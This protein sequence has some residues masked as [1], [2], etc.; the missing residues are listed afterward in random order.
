MREKNVR[1]FWQTVLPILFLSLLFS[2]CKVV[3]SISEYNLPKEGLHAE[4]RDKPKEA[5]EPSSFTKTQISLLASTLKGLNPYI[6]QDY[7]IEMILKL[8]YQGLMTLTASGEIMEQLANEVILSEDTLSCQIDLGE[9]YFHNGSKVGYKDILYSW[10]K[11]KEGRYAEEVAAIKKISPLKND[12]IQVD[13]HTKGK[14]NLY[15]LVFPIVADKSLEKGNLRE[16]NGTGAYRLI[17]YKPMQTMT[18][19]SEWN[20]LEVRLSR[21]ENVIR[22]G[23]LHGLTDI[24]YA[25][26]FPWFSFSEETLKNISKFPGRY[27]YYMGFHSNNPVLADINHRQY[28]LH[29]LDFEE[30]KKTAFL[31]HI[32]E[33]SLPFYR[34]FEWE[35]NQEK[36]E[37]PEGMNILDSNPLPIGQ[38][39]KLI[40]VSEDISMKILAERLLQEWQPYIGMEIAGY[41]QADFDKAVLAGDYDVYLAKMPLKETPNMRNFLGSSGK[42]NYS[43]VAVFDSAVEVFMQ[44]DNDE[45]LKK[46]YLQLAKE[47]TESKWILPFGFKENAIIL[48]N[49]V[50]G[51][52]TPKTYD[53]LSGIGELRVV[54]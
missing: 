34:G 4:K 3:E 11:A 39:L 49:Q 5:V 23:F 32:I 43:K 1:K 52:I 35:L 16:I 8:C 14:L 41:S 33:Q 54:K 2:S 50:K 28:L 42:Y 20:E 9:K 47:M 53:L 25:D 48:N 29:K 19:K 36:E 24:Y 26:E 40:Y 10:Q 45:T 17:E 15:S 30:L 37:L 31:N 21:T 7:S 27:F 12:R 6:A 22:D 18:L 13:F 51:P 46:A 44:A 38:K